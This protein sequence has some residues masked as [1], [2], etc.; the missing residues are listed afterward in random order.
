MLK[1]ITI[2]SKLIAYTAETIFQVQVGRYNKGRYKTKYSFTGNIS[3]AWFWYNGINI[4]N[5]YKKRLVMV[6][7]EVPR[8]TTLAK[9][10]S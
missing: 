2:N 10:N 1:T 9:E 3:R 6:G 4:G 5:G 8:M 7:L